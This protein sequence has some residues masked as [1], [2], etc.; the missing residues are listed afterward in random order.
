MVNPAPDV[1]RMHYPN[2]WNHPPFTGHRQIR[3]STPQQL[4]ALPEPRPHSMRDI[5]R[6]MAIFNSCYSTNS[7]GRMSAGYS[8]LMAALLPRPIV[9]LWKCMFY[10]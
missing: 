9:V 3:P 1:M 5:Y 2:P 4:R 6:H 8:P 10:V 7:R